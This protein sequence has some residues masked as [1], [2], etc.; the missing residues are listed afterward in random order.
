MTSR[1]DLLQLLGA[2]LMVTPSLAQ[3]SD[4]SPARRHHAVE[5]IL[6][7]ERFPDSK[8][9]PGPTLGSSATAVR[10]F[11]GDLT[12]IW[13]HDLD[14]LWKARPAAIAGVTGSDALFVLE[15]LARG[16]GLKLVSRAPAGPRSAAIIWLIA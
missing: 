10:R 13:T 9:F 8:A 3:A 16:P 1:R 6:I 4:P 2:G 14:G 11:R 5:R 15:Q 12:E 7:D